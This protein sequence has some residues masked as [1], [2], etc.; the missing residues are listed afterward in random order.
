MKATDRHNLIG[1]I[2]T[3]EGLTD[4]ERSALLGLIRESKTYGLVWEDKPEE[5]EERLRAEIPVLVEDKDRALIDAGPN[6]PN[7]ILIEGDNLEALTTLAYTH[8]GKID[9]IYI[10]PPYNTGNKDFVYNDSY[11]DIEDSYRHSKWLS[12]MKKRLTIAKKILKRDGF[13]C[14]SIDDNEQAALKLLCDEIFGSQNFINCISVKTKASSGAS[15]GGEDKKFKKNIEYLLIYAKSASDVELNF[16]KSATPLYDYIMDKKEKGITW[17]YTNVMLNPGRKEYLTSTEAGNGEEIKIYEVKDYE[18]ISV[19][20][21]AKKLNKSE[22]DIYIEYIDKI[23]TTENAQTSIRQ[24]VANAVSGEGLYIAEYVPVSGRNKGKLTE[25]GFI[26]D[27]KRLVSYLKYT[28]TIKSDG[29]YKLEKIGTLWHDLSWS[30]VS[31]EGGIAFP[32]GKKPISL[33][34]RIVS[35]CFDKNCIVLD[36]FAGSGSTGHAVMSINAEDLGKRTFIT[37]TNN[38]NRICETK[39]YP[40]LRNVVNGYGKNDGLNNNNLRYYRTDFVGRSRSTKNMRRLVHLSTDILCI[41][42]NLY[43]EKKTFAGLPT[44]KNIYRYFEQGNKKMLVIYDERYV[45]EIVKMIEKL[46]TDTNIKVYV[47]SPSEDPWEASFEPV[48]DKVE[49]CA[50]PQALYNTYKRILPKPKR[51]PL[52]SEEEDALSV[53]DEKE[54][55]GLFAEEGGDE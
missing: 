40:R 28:C 31:K 3:I 16:P 48:N 34:K 5:V 10:D 22:E 52:E 6:A 4:D 9:V 37:V 24:R 47:F 12:F 30:S 20:S 45:D 13:I 53:S 50:L 35:L 49:L 8:T 7:H 33:I 25:V 11:V 42:E 54:I 1:R 2:N 36:F 46:E 26:G 43:A 51:K 19:S 29:V 27:T 41:K 38:E 55:G 14:I 21:L 39:T 18:I 15:G 32:S 17:S 44:F 23:F